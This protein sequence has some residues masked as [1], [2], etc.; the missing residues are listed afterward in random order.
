MVTSS[1]DLVSGLDWQHGAFGMAVLKYQGAR[2]HCPLQRRSYR[3]NSQA[4]KSFVLSQTEAI[5]ITHRPQRFD[6]VSQNLLV[7]QLTKTAAQTTK[8]VVELVNKN[9][10]SLIKK[11][12]ESAKTDITIN[13]EKY[14]WWRFLQRSGRAD[15]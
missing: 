8:F 7:F 3:A 2:F 9:C 11:L 1:S 14:C 13:R 6:A 5:T 12:H 4:K 15:Q 10:G